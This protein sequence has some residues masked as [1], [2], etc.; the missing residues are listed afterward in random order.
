MTRMN[1]LVSLVLCLAALVLLGSAC[2]T[3]RPAAAEVDGVDISQDALD[4]EL[5]AINGNLQYLQL[6][7]QQGFRIQGRGRNTLDMNFVSQTLTRQIL[8]RLI[9]DEVV[10]RDLIISDTDLSEAEAGVRQ[11]VGGPEVFS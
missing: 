4:D 8:Y 11:S 3:A 7:Q 1:R 9:H 10:R 6:I 2:G 5:D